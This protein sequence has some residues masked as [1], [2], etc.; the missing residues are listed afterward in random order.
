LLIVHPLQDRRA[1]HP[2]E[3]RPSTASTAFTG[4]IQPELPTTSDAI[5][6]LTVKNDSVRASRRMIL[7][8]ECFGILRE[9][10]LGQRQRLNTS[11][12]AVD[13]TPDGAD[14]GA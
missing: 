8:N 5:P 4:S 11:E 2:A 3:H 10:V 14:D 9:D 13:R 6:A 7:G 12:A 1:A